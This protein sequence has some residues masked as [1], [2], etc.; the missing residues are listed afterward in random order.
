M[1]VSISH[2]GKAKQETKT[3]LKHGLQK[4]ETKVTPGHVE[5]TPA[6]VNAEKLVEFL[7]GWDHFILG[8]GHF[9]VTEKGLKAN[10]KIT[11][12]EK[13]KT[14]NTGMKFQLCAY[15]FWFNPF[16]RQI[17][18]RSSKVCHPTHSYLHWSWGHSP[19]HD[20]HLVFLPSSWYKKLQGAKFLTFS[21][22]SSR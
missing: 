1:L 2:L 14:L 9:N 21:W 4:V 6:P 8:W 15:C 17:P 11:T 10:G 22:T 7:L 20:Q 19:Q 16:H 12:K 18:S 5:R 3:W 13:G